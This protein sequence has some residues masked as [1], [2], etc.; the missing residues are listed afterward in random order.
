MK[1]HNELHTKAKHN[2]HWCGILDKADKIEDSAAAK[3]MIMD[4]MAD[5]RDGKVA[6]FAS[7]YK[8]SVRIGEGLNYM[9]NWA[10]KD[11]NFTSKLRGQAV[12]A[13]MD[14]KKAGKS[15][16]FEVTHQLGRK[17]PIVKYALYALA[18]SSSRTFAQ[19]KLGLSG[20]AAT[21]IGHLEAINPLPVGIEGL[22]DMGEDSKMLLEGRHQSDVNHIYHCGKPLYELNYFNV[23]PPPELWTQNPSAYF[24]ERLQHWGVKP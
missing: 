23:P 16:T 3:K 7:Y 13:A 18:L 10:W 19:E 4:H 20:M 8:E 12:A 11:G 1:T 9:D 14:A 22:Y 17:T 21:A 5:I 15:I 2:E 24:P 6:E